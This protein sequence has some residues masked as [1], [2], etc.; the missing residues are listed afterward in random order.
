MNQQ[1]V[2]VENFTTS[3]QIDDKPFKITTIEETYGEQKVDIVIQNP[4]IYGIT[5]DESKLL[6]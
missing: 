4:K 1:T 6:Y 5:K 3:L 2:L